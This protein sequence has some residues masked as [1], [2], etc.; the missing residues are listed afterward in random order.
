M[1]GA[2]DSGNKAP[3]PSAGERLEAAQPRTP[4]MSSLDAAFSQDF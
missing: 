3:A 1:P 2:I 4:T